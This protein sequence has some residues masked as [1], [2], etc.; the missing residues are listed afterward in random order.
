MTGTDF[1]M[2]QAST[3]P[4]TMRGI[5]T[6]AAFWYQTVAGGLPETVICWLVPKT[7]RAEMAMR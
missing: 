2:V 7:A 3:A 1:S 6:K 5:H 4:T